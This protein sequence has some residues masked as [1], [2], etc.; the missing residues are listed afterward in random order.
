MVGDPCWG[1]HGEWGLPSFCFVPSSGFVSSGCDRSQPGAAMWGAAGLSAAGTAPGRA[2]G[3]P[4][5]TGDPNSAQAREKGTGWWGGGAAVPE[6]AELGTCLG[7]L[8]GSCAGSMGRASTEGRLFPTSPSAGCGGSGG[9]GPS[10]T[11]KGLRSGEWMERG[12]CQGPGRCLKSCP[13]A[14]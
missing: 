4:A 1:V 11:P 3:T 12:G 7:S 6:E 14:W 8:V 10:G 13:R 2:W 9:P 5:T